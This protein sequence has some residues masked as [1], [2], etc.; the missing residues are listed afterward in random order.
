MTNSEHVDPPLAPRPLP[1]AAVAGER[2]DL[3]ADLSRIVGPRQVLTADRATRHYTRGA[4]LWLGP[5]PRGRQV[6]LAG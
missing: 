3:M 6:R 4:P 2:G 1:A 5:G